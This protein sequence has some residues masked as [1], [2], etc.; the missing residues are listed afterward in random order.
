MN[1]FR[2][3]LHCHTTCS[4]GS[5]SPE[6]IVRLAVENGL[7]GLSITDHDTIAAYTTAIPVAKELGLKLLT[8]VEFSA[9]HKNTSIHVL[10][11]GFSLTN[12]LIQDFC[13]QHTLRRRERNQTILTLLKKEGISISEQELHAEYGPSSKGK[14]W[15]RPH[16]AQAMVKKGFVKSVEEA[17]RK[18]IGDGKC[19][20]APGK[21]FSVAETIELIHAANGFAVLAHPM[22]I[23]KR[24]VAHDLL[25]LPFDGIEAYYA[26]ISIERQL[27]WKRIAEEQGMMIT[28]GSDFHGQLKPNIPLGCSWVNE[29]RFN[30]LMK[31]DD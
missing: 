16:I 3:D 10:A 17:F 29:E 23:D 22:L 13:D 24:S 14:S 28:G 8:G 12:V 19:A 31:D 18:F 6:Q 7:S 2:A 15:G 9:E 1:T 4:D 30:E 5:L 26:K 11:Y 27:H 21:T 25:N 20:Y